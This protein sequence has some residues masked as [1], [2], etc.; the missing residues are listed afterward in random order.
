MITML[1]IKFIRENFDLFV[2]KMQQRGVEID[3]E[4][5]LQLDSAKRFLIQNSE[6]CQQEKNKIIK[7]IALK[8]RN[9]DNCDDL[10]QK[11]NEI[12]AKIEEI[13]QQLQEKTRELDEILHVLPNLPDDSVP[14]GNN[15]NNNIERKKWGEIPKF[16]F[17]PKP[18][19]ELHED[20][21][22]FKISSVISGSRFCTLFGDLAILERKLMDFFLQE[23]IRTGYQ[24]VSPPLLVREN[25]MFGTGQLPKFEED[26]F[27]TTDGYRL[28]PTAEVP[29]TNLVANKII[30][31]K[32]LPLRFTAATPCFR[33]EA[34]SS[35]KD[36]QGMIRLHQF[37]KVEIV[38]IVH[39]DESV[40][41]LER[42]TLHAESLL[43]KLDLPYRR[44]ELC[45]GDL[46]FCANKTY[47]L[48][49]WMPAQNKFREISSC[50]NCSDFQARRMKAR[51]KQDKK[52]HFVHT[53]NG[54]ALAVGRTMAALLE[55]C[56][57]ETDCVKFL[58]AKVNNLLEK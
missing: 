37:W 12:T 30:D 42:M 40:N 29:L 16:D 53:L 26:S 58:L 48:E 15:E 44:I 45:T 22:D 21:M 13:T 57:H 20:L 32:N 56:Q 23:N 4:M 9:Q 35:G 5:I 28:I 25:A 27:A 43:A 46:G 2:Q 1:D 14:I 36:T 31:I 41:E 17:Q 47:D 54:S 50:S 10:M 33:S 38:S 8:K 19:H 18:H 49:V 24:I 39:P 52:N 3:F 7:E 55:N 11:T 51:F 34:G 6:N